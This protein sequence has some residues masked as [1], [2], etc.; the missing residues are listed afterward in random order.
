MPRTARIIAA[1]RRRASPDVWVGAALTGLLL[2]DTFVTTGGVALG[3]NTWSEIVI[4]FAAVALGVVVL[5]RAAPGRAWGAPALCLFTALTVLTVV[6]ISWSVQPADTWIESSRTLSY[7]ATFAGALALARLIPRRWPA[8]A[9]TIAVASTV[10]CAYSLLVKVY[11]ATFDPLDPL[12]RVNLPFGYWNAVGLV[13]ALGL[14]ACLWAGARSGTARV[15]RALAV[16]AISILITSLVLTYSRSAIIGAVVGVG[17][18]IAAVPLRLRATLVLALGALGAAGAVAWALGTHA[19][20]NDD[21]TLAARTS[22]GHSFGLVLL[23]TVAV[24]TAIGFAGALALDRGRLAPPV[25]RRIGAVLLVALALVPVAGIGALAASS[26]G[27][28]GEISHVW[29]EFTSPNSGGTGDEAGRL[30]AV[31]N[32]RGTYWNEALKV[33]EHHL[34]GGVGA[35]GFATAHGYYNAN[36]QPNQHAHGYLF[37]TFADLGLI[38]LAVSLALLVTWAVAALRSIGVVG[39]EPGAGDVTASERAER[40]GLLTLLAVVLAFGAQSAVDWT[41]FIPGTALPALFCAGWL[42]GRGPLAHPVGVGPSRVARLRTPALGA[43]T[44]AVV[45]ALVFGAW[46]MLAPLRSQNALNAAITALGHGRTSE[47]LADARTAANAEPDSV[48]P[49]LVLSEIDSLVG[50]PAEGR[51][52]LVKATQIQPGNAE[53]MRWLGEY[54][55]KRRQLGRAMSEFNR[56]LALDL[57]S[58][59]TQQDLATLRQ[60]L[61][62]VLM[63]NYAPS[64]S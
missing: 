29:H 8:V 20:T 3:A 24:A 31:D 51:A 17:F 12:G 30:L 54:D 57:G 36:V 5:A 41:W 53:P 50:L 60:E 39:A 27:L 7:L 22:A 64:H 23:L 44:V 19:L 37:Q 56:A 35:G 38:G 11:P 14:P 33:G 58:I 34:L 13:A 55:L 26:R 10:V 32:S 25:R 59:Q 40:A 42:A 16:P 49:Y 9:G 4:A 61:E 2:L 63:H 1:A 62:A 21:V 18:W 46:L 6:S 43:A 47:A 52:E 28:T 48:D 45:A 15:S